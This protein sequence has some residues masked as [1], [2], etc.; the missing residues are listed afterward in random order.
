MFVDVF[1]KKGEKVEESFVVLSERS[2]LARGC[3]V[4]SPRRR[5]TGEGHIVGMLK[6][7]FMWS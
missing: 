1:E 4:I 3:L 6:A 5:E 7:N 2:V